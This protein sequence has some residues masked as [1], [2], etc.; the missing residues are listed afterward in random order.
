MPMAVQLPPVASSFMKRVLFFVCKK[1][2]CG[3]E[4]SKLKVNK[5]D[6]SVFI[7]SAVR[8]ESTY[9]KYVVFGGR[10]E[11]ERFTSFPLVSVRMTMRLLMDL[12]S[13]VI[14]RELSKTTSA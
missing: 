14:G 1:I 3:L 7:S 4:V 11:R 5:P 9:L 10:L 8:R 13:A 2:M 6:E 12:I